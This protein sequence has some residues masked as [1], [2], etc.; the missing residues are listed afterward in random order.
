[1]TDR[2]GLIA[3]LEAEGRSLIEWYD[4]PHTH[5][6]EH[7][8]PTDEVLVILEGS[9]SMRVEGTDHDLGPGDRIELPGGAMHTATVGE[10]GARYLVAR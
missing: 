5:Y 8:H 3:A 9:M 10:H 4:E 6:T 1:V 2:A 7:A